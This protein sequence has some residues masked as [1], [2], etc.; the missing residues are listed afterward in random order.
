MTDAPRI[1]SLLS[2]TGIKAMNSLCILLE[3]AHNIF[4]ETQLRLVSECEQRID[5]NEGYRN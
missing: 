3:T 2:Q 5:R 1:P 4:A